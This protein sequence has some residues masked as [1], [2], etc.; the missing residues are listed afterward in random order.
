M[1]GY[2]TESV[3]VEFE[4]SPAGGETG[5]EDVDVDLDGLFVVDLFVDEF[6]HLVVHD[7]KGLH[8]LR[9][10]VQEFVGSG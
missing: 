1:V 3:S 8:D 6:D 7:T 4:S 9:V 5:H 2:S 10:V